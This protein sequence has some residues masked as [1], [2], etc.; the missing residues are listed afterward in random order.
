M[1]LR[2]GERPPRDPDHLQPRLVG[3]INWRGIWTLY[4]KGIQRLLRITMQSIVA[5]VATTLLLLGLV[6]VVQRRR[7][8]MAAETV[9]AS[10]T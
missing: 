1:N 9:F 5:P 4:A 3:I 10:A 7:N 8:G 6:V 2:V